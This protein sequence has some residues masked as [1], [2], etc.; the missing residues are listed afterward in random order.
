M[1][2]LLVISN[3]SSKENRVLTQ[4]EVAIPGLLPLSTEGMSDVISESI[5]LSGVVGFAPPL[6]VNREKRATSGAC[7][8][9]SVC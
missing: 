5:Y 3:I 8:P 2:Y 1:L 9:G 4:C 6:P 7:S